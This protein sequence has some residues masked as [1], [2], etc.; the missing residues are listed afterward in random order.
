MPRLPGSAGRCRA[1]APD[2]AGRGVREGHWETLYPSAWA[3]LTIEFC[4]AGSSDSIVLP[5]VRAG[6]TLAAQIASW[7]NWP[8]PQSD[9]TW[10]E[11]PLRA[12]R[13][14]TKYPAASCALS[15]L[16]AAGA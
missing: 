2:R 12:V 15:Q 6:L 16:S 11:A 7:L 14:P 4:Q 9:Q 13:S 3:Y 1:G 10:E 8:E 5:W